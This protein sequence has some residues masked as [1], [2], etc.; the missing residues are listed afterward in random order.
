MSIRNPAPESLRRHPVRAAFAFGGTLGMMFLVG[1]GVFMVAGSAEA[2]PGGKKPTPTGVSTAT[3]T[4]TATFTPTAFV[5]GAPTPAPT[6]EAPPPP[7]EQRT[8]PLG[9]I[10]ADRAVVHTGDGDC[11][12][13]R[14]VPSKK[15]ES[16]PRFCLNEGEIV[17]LHGDAIEGDGETWRYAL[18]RGWLATRF[19]Y[20]E[21]VSGRAF[22]DGFSSLVLQ[23]T[24]WLN[25]ASV[26]DYTAMDVSGKLRPLGSLEYRQ[27]GIGSGQSS[28]SP[29]G[30]Y[31][32]VTTSTQSGDKL[33]M[34]VRHL[35]SG[36]E[37]RVDNVSDGAWSHDGKLLVQPQGCGDGCPWSFG[38]F[39][40]STGEVTRY[41]IPG[42]KWVAPSWLPDGS[43][44]IVS[45]DCR[46]L[47]RVTLGGA[48]TK[49]SEQ[50]DEKAC[51]SGLV[52]SPDQSYGLVGGV[53]GPL[54][55]VDLAN[56]AMREFT[57]A[58]RI[59]EPAGKCGGSVGQLV[60]VLDNGRI[61][62]HESLA[63]KGS[64]GIT[65]GDVAT[66]QRRVLS[67]W[68]IADLDAIGPD[69]VT[70]TSFEQMNDVSFQLTWLLDTTTG[71]AR[72]VAVGTEAAW[73]K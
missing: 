59:V 26:T 48:V 35:E 5:A 51:Y 15:F 22:L 44:V 29:D 50:Q 19:V 12:N 41:T 43:G 38:V 1:A 58:G 3:L 18:G 68:N 14:P 71:E 67:F 42:E 56:G 39:D 27:W 16:D 32:V 30:R 46:R 72:P 49:I 54:R 65:I 64:N 47:Y 36:S 62:Y 9:P 7:K 57:R 60:D 61:V 63:A 55:I 37:Y 6:K 4:P 10:A 70:F 23:T 2:E 34:V 33:T 24:R 69:R 40:T 31:A 21:P 13:V 11:L 28:I 45:G 20:M 53:Y 66:G 52:V 17:Y 73:I 25:E 8:L